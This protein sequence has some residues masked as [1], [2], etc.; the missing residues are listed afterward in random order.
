MDNYA[1]KKESNAGVLRKWDTLTVGCL[2]RA[3]MRPLSSY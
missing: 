2:F 1:K 3:F